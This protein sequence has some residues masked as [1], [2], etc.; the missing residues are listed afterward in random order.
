M[1]PCVL[2]SDGIVVEN[3]TK[4]FPRSLSL[5]TWARHRGQPPR[6][7]A[8]DD[9]S[10]RVRKGELFG[11][12]G[13]NGAGKS[14]ILQVLAGLVTPDAGRVVVNGVDAKRDPVGVRRQV[15]FCTAE[16]RS[17]YYRL[18]A[19]RNFEFFGTLA[20]LS[21]SALRERIATV[22]S[23]VD[24]TSSL[25]RRFETFSSGM[26]QRLAIARAMLGEPDVL[27][28]DEPTRAVD[29]VHAAEIRSF[30]RRL[31][32]DHG[33]TVVLCTN[34]L[35]EAWEL[36]DRVAVIARGRVVTV[37]TPQDLVASTR[38]RR[39]SI[40][41]D[42]VDDGLVGRTQAVAGVSNVTFHRD[43]EGI[44]MRA[45]LDENARTLT[46]LLHAASANGLTIKRVEL[47]SASPFEVF[48]RL[49][50]ELKDDR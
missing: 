19:R 23:M 16:E 39:Y 18:S 45:E 12:L 22:T 30:V 15:G 32:T 11:L 17:F 9:V 46:D 50:M 43:R 14:T 42:E 10:F 48:S 49:A 7:L 47:D 38:A 35:E 20:G 3:L 41:F 44:R 36:C 13:A 5:S 6:F 8:A 29:P 27:L 21:G 31:V 37:A 24:L 25:D 34:L 33:K 28:L 26:R 1:G 4:T 40:V 2:L